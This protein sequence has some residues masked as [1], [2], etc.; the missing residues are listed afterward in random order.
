MKESAERP[1]KDT[2]SSFFSIASFL[3]LMATAVLLIVFYRMVSINAIVEVG[4]QSNTVVA[5]TILQIL[6][7]R[8]LDYLAEADHHLA[9]ADHHLAEDKHIPEVPADLEKLIKRSIDETHVARIKIYDRNGLVCF[10]SKESQIGRDQ[11]LNPGFIS[12]ARGEAKSKLNY[13][14]RFNYFD[15]ES[16]DDNLIQ[17]YLPI[18]S[19]SADSVLGVLE[20]Y[21]NVEPLVKKIETTTLL[22]IAGISIILLLLYIFLRLVIRRLQKIIDRQTDTITE[23]NRLLEL[24]SARMLSSEEQGRKQTATQLHEGL[25]QDLNAIKFTMEQARPQMEKI[26]NDE[27]RLCFDTLLPTL[28]K[29]IAQVRAI[30]MDLRPP[31]LD[32]IGL[33]PTIHWVCREFESLH[34]DT[35][36]KSEIEIDESQVP[37]EV[38]SVMFRTIRDVLRTIAEHA[39]TDNVWISIT[40]PEHD[41]ELRI[42]GGTRVAD[43]SEFPIENAHSVEN[44]ISSTLDRVVLSGGH[45]SIDRGRHGGTGYQFVWNTS[46]RLASGRQMEH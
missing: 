8:L 10:S 45:Y 43:L 2:I 42:S 6:K 25:A 28:Q 39:M 37:T 20:V 44:A 14:D 9:E 38:K 31:S 12:A 16:E 30:A 19:T 36:V 24:L 3:G 4:E 41:I 18:Y 22:A 46:P 32:D 7:S 34:P 1:A 35:T 23:R 40:K 11:R 27:V 5:N 15:Q 21:T 33:I 13:H 26:D 29:I 17:T